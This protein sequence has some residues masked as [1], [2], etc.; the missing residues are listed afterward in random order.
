V[1]KPLRIAN[2]RALQ[3][4]KAL[5]MTKRLNL[6]LPSRSVERLERLKGITE[7]GSI[8]EVVKDALKTYD[9]LVTHLK[10]GSTFEVIKPD[11]SRISVEFVV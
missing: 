9:S 1:E 11:G 4:R 3:N 8:T 2:K 10:D 6:A 7:A 5:D